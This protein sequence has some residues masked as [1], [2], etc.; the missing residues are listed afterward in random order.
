M[1]THPNG[2]AGRWTFFAFRWLFACALCG[3]VFAQAPA[4]DP[5]VVNEI[6]ANTLRLSWNDIYSDEDG[7]RLDRYDASTGITMTIGWLG[8]DV[9]NFL[10]TGL[11][12]GNWYYYNVVAFNSAGDSYP[13]FA[14][15]QATP[16]PGPHPL[17]VD[18][19]TANTI[20]LS[21]NDIYN[22]EDGFRL[23]RYDPL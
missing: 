23:N 16:V 8:P 3:S 4:P 20:R 12:P 14:S 19:I 13:A 5:L 18:E 6:T 9:T 11:T 22:N 10:D 1:M 2:L 21:W 15:A 17:V 7:F